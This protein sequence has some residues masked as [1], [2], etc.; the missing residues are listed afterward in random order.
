VSARPGPGRREIA[1]GLGTYAGYLAVRRMVWHESGRARAARNA[2]RIAELQRRVVGDVE[3][4]L[5]GLATRAPRVVDGLNA[6]YAVGNVGVTVGSLIRWYARRDP[7]FARERRAAVAA[8]AAAWPVFLAFPTA[9][10]RRQGDA[11]DTLAARGL[12][13]EH[14]LV[15]RFYNPI[16]AMP[17]YHVAFAVVTAGGFAERAAGRAGRMAAYGYA[18][19]VAFVVVVTGNHYVADVVAGA[20]LGLLARRLTR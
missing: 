4:R 5:Q 9:P 14:P 6:A 8:F 1:I 18:P 15:V 2:K 12:D 20:G 16:A 13:L 3:R 19:L 10:P 7:A 17:S 11:V